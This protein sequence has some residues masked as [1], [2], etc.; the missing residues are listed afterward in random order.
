MSQDQLRGYLHDLVCF[1]A[2]YAIGSLLTIAEPQAPLR[3]NG[4]RFYAGELQAVRQREAL[5]RAIR[6]K[7]DYPISGS[8]QHLTLRSCE[9]A[10]HITHI[11]RSLWPG[12]DFEP[13]SVHKHAPTSG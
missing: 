10:M 8:C 3:I 1:L 12:R 4:H 6:M 5:A 11:T 7:C 2:Q 9:H 13:F